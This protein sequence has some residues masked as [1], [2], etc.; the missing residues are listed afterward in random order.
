MHAALSSRIL[1]LESL[2]DEG[3]LAGMEF[4]LMRQLLTVFRD[5]VDDM[6]IPQKRAAIRTVMRKVVWDGKVAHVGQFRRSI[7]SIT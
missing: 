2:T 4:D 5:S 3:V 7:F 1:E 6:T